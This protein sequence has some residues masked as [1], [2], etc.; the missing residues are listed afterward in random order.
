MIRKIIRQGNGTLTITLPKKWSDEIGLLGKDQVEMFPHQRGL[1][2]A[3]VEPRKE[4]TI[5][6]DVDNFERLSLAKFLIGCYEL[7]FDTIVMTFTKSFVKSWNA[8]P[9]PITDV[10][11]F[12]V[13]RLVGFEILSQTKNSITIGNI[14]R[15][16]EKFDALF[17]RVFFLIEENLRLF[18]DSAKDKAMLKDYEMRHDNVTKIIVLM[19]REVNEHESFSKTEAVNYCVILNYLDKVADF[20]RYASKYALMGK[21][22]IAKE[23]LK[24]ATLS[25]DFFESYR[26]LYGKFEYEKANKMDELRG[27]A[28]RFFITCKKSKEIACIS[29]FDA[30][31]ET[32]HGAM[33]SLIIIHIDKTHSDKPTF[34]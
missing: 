22:D 1:V 28:K 9:Q 2:I 30:L 4:R 24:M 16:H 3:P 29:Q 19:L 12:F 21:G 23:T 25:L 14:A 10:I 33:K 11:S 27:E 8:P 31:V 26:S 32:L 7:G 18:I 17:S 20:I 13:S 34:S 15:R 6:I 5:T